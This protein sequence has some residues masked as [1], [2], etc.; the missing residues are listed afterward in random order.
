VRRD[1]RTL[2]GPEFCF[3][4]FWH[5]SPRS[6][7]PRRRRRGY[8]LVELVVASLLAVLLGSLLATAFIT[9]GRPAIEV[10]ARTRISREA[11]LA[12]QSV[13][14]DLG[15]FLADNP[16]RTGPLGH[17]R[18]TEWDLSD[19]NV[20]LLVFQGSSVKTLVVIRYEI[21]G[22]RLVRTNS[23]T[24]ATTTIAN[25]VTGFKVE[26]DPDHSNRS[27]I[28]ISITYRDYTAIYSVIGIKPS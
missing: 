17:Y 13:A 16:G 21:Q 14:C 20:L 4:N 8:S 5:M 3:A 25:H 19:P 7:D 27:L 18:F 2:V 26:I 22:N 10:E 15:G 12:V 11:I 9:F 1:L 23:D 24:G 28:H 6:V